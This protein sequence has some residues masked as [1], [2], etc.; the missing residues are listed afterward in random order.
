[1]PYIFIISC[2]LRLSS[3]R[4]T[5]EEIFSFFSFSTLTSSL[6]LPRALRKSSVRAS[7]SSF[8]SS[9][10]TSSLKSFGYIGIDSL[11][12][13][14]FILFLTLDMGDKSG[15]DVVFQDNG[16]HALLPEHVDVLALLDL[17]GHI[18]DRGLRF[19]LVLFLL[20]GIGCLLGLFLG[21]FFLSRFLRM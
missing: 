17:I 3:D 14:V 13:N 7:V 20:S 15:I 9:A 10:E 8:S 2:I 19:L 21:F 11:E 12:M 18:V 6:S 1:M 4:V 5:M 16:V